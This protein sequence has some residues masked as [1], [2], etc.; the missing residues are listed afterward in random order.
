MPARRG[1]R[2]VAGVVRLAVRGEV[3]SLGEAL[4]ADGALV[5]LLPAV[6]A[7]VALQVRAGHQGQP[8]HVARVRLQPRVGQLVHLER[9]RVDERLPAQVA[10]EHKHTRCF[11]CLVP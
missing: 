6:H 3:V 1:G 10:L 4:A 9:R 5:A 7:L 2:G 11:T 8:T